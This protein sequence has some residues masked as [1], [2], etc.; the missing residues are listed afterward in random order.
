MRSVVVEGEEWKD[1]VKEYRD[2]IEKQTGKPLDEPDDLVVY[3][4]RI[5]IGSE[6]DLTEFLNAVTKRSQPTQEVIDQAK[7]TF[8]S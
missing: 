1:E 5:C 8:R 7:D 4:L 3:V 2:F 6:E